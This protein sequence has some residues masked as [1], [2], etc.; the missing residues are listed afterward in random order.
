MNNPTRVVEEHEGVE[1][2]TPPHRQPPTL[3]GRAQQPSHMVFEE[4]D[5]DLDGVGATGEIVLPALPPSVKFM[6]TSTMIQLL[7]LKSMSE[8][9]LVMMTINT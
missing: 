7:N 8:V 3:R 6:I 1:E 5:M 9:Q 2:I 4:D